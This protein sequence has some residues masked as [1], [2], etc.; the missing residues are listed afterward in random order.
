MV[1][2]VVSVGRGRERDSEAGLAS[3]QSQNATA[4][5]KRLRA[6]CRRVDKACRR[7]SRLRTMAWAAGECAPATRAINVPETRRSL[8]SPS[9]DCGSPR[10]RR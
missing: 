10:R 6:R 9:T 1:V 3:R 7:V 5:R 2:S 8:R 4:L